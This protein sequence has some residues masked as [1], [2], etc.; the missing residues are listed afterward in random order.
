MKKTIIK[1]NRGKII[2]QRKD[3]NS[4]CGI[5]FED[6]PSTNESKIKIN[7]NIQLLLNKENPIILNDSELKT[8]LTE[9]ISMEIIPEKYGLIIEEKIDKELVGI[10]EKIEKTEE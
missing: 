8:K 5:M 3:D 7:Q 4:I 10:I 9:I 6:V 1:L 2:I